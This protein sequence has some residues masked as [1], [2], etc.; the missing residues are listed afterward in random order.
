MSWKQRK[1]CGEVVEKN[2]GQTILLNG[3][4]DAIRD[5]GAVLFLHIRDVTGLVQVVF[6][7][8]QTKAYETAQALRSEWVVEII[9]TVHKR[10]IS[11]F[12][13]HISTGEL[14]VVVDTI[15]ILNKA[16]TPPFL[17]SEK[18]F[19]DVQQADLVDE[20][21][22][23]RYRYLDLRRA[24]MQ[25]NLI[26]RYTF[27]KMVRDY[28][29]E[30]RFIEIETPV[31]T[32][33]TPEGARDYLVPSRTHTNKFFALPQ[34]PQLFKQ[35]LMMSGF[36][37]YFQIVKCF[38]DEDLRPNRQPEFTQIDLEAS[39]IDETYIFELL[40]GLMVL[41][42]KKIGVELSTPFPKITYKDS[43]EKYG[44]D[45]PDLRFGWDMVDVTSVF[46]NTSYKIF[47]SIVHSGGLIKGINL[48]QQA[49]KLSKNVLQDDLAKTLIQKL[50]AKG[51]TWMKVENGQLESNIVQ[52]F[53]ETEK[54]ELFPLMKAEDG[55]VLVFVAD[56][57]HATVLQALGQFRTIMAERLGLIAPNTFFPC[58]VVDFP[59]F[60]TSAE[61]SLTSVHHPFT[62]AQVPLEGL[63]TTD[64][65]KVNA[66][67]YD[68]VINGEEVGG[69]SIRIHNWDQQQHIFSLLGLSE[70]D[71]NEKFGFFVKALK[72]GAPPHGGLALGVDRLISMLL[73]TE[74]IREVI[75]FPKNRVAYCPLTQA[76]DFVS[77]KQLSDLHIQTLSPEEA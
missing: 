74:S 22:R 1:F 65:L 47:N 14:E 32:K 4:V 38:R 17:I 48:K 31:L 44:N 35:L 8:E 69:G 61:G 68:L 26:S 16:E 24:P 54:N 70:A 58:W 10:D 21:T 39:F 43:M 46:K 72:F 19:G 71:I 18:G 20:E 29:H 23:L 11:T 7:P 59:L 55:D 45:R 25:H 63:S 57:N 66:R 9:G 33:S 53:S 40:E 28:L 36:E 67:A 64:L 73:Q 51:L 6:K 12:N 27:L 34:S 60:E 50:G 15:T 3:W 42:F 2:I 37:R 75:A 13:P 62:Q 52:F 49:S 77:P 5:H 56:T 30:N 41:L 76:P